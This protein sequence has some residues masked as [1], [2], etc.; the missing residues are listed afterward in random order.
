MD[1]RMENSSGAGYE[2]GTITFLSHSTGAHE[3]QSDI[4]CMTMSAPESVTQRLNPFAFI[5]FPRIHAYHDV[6]Q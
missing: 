6:S 4:Y 1:T 2:R 5:D 3:S